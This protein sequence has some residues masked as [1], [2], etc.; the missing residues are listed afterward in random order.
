MPPPSP[1]P[2]HLADDERFG[3]SSEPTRSSADD[4]TEESSRQTRALRTAGADPLNVFTEFRRKLA[5]G[6]FVSRAAAK[7]A[8]ALRFTG[9]VTLTFHQ[10]RLTK[11]VLEESYFKGGPMT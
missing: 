9:R 11:T 2:S 5:T 3:R 8:E 7:L 10:G 1:C 6:E 4:W